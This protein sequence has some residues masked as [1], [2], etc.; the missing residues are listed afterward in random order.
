MTSEV[1]EN[2]TAGTTPTVTAQASEA[3]AK[4]K[5]AVLMAMRLE[6]IED[7]LR[8]SLRK[9]NALEANLGAVST[10]LM[11]MACRLK[12]AI[13]ERLGKN[14]LEDFEKLMPAIDAYLRVARQIERLVTLAQRLVS[15]HAPTTPSKPR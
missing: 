3:D 7:Q 10:D 12:E 13:E 6:K 14:P 15:P 4:S 11:L 9:A 1:T 5:A 8:E 2:I